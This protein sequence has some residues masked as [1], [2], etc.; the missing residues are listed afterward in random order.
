MRYISQEGDK[1]EIKT[2]KKKARYVLIPKVKS[3][4]GM[5]VSPSSKTARVE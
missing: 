3:Q 4:V 1:V 5:Y 2:K